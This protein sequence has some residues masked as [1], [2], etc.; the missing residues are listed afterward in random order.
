MRKRGR[1]QH[2]AMIMTTARDAGLG[3]VNLAAGYRQRAYHRKL[4]SSS[5][6]GRAAPAGV[7][8]PS[9]WAM[10]FSHNGEAPP[11]DFEGR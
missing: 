6:A 7:A 11:T 9:L 8:A 5:T 1:R 2:I 4:H 3:V 10:G